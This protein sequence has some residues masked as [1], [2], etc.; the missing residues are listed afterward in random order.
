MPI[1]ETFS[2]SYIAQDSH[3]RDNKLHLWTLIQETTAHVRGAASQP[4]LPTPV[5]KY[6]MD[7]NAL[8]YCRF[9]LLPLPTFSDKEHTALIALPN[10]IESSLVRAQYV[11]VCTMLPEHTSTR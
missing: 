10:L 7:V 2:R 3:G 11:D 6:S 8:N 1:C 4:G 5:L 9:S